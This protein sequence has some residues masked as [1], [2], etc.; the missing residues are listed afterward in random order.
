MDLPLIGPG[1]VMGAAEAGL[2]AIVIEAGGVMVL[3]QPQV[4]AL[5]DAHGISLWV[6]EA[7]A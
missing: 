5:C 1:T 4:R 7:G 2:A 6:R 3:D